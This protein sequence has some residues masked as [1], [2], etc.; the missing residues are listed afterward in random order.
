M[1]KTKYR[2]VG[3]KTEVG[4]INFLWDADIPVQNIINSKLDKILAAVP[5][6]STDKYSAT[7][8]QNP[9][10]LGFVTI[11]IKGAPENILDKCQTIH[12]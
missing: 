7:V 5:F 1:G 10:R 12:T 3:N 6:N 4:L 2:A 9:N 11:Y 8:V